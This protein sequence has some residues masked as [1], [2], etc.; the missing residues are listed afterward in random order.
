M[1]NKT[2]YIK[3]ADMPLWDRAQ[4]E[5]GDNMSSIL[6]D[7]LKER[8]ERADPVRAIDSLLSIINKKYDLDLERHPAWSPVILAM[9][10][11]KIGYKLHQRRERIPIGS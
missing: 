2:I 8:L 9:D 11:D 1:P 4:Q 5:P 10:T 6:I 3:N 7:C